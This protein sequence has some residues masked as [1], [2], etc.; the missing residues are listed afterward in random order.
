MHIIEIIYSILYTTYY[1]SYILI[2]IIYYII[3]IRY[4]HTM[5]IYIKDTDIDRK[6]PFAE[7]ASFASLSKSLLNSS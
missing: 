4:I 6:H 2:S 7:A 3:Y 5:C 1:I